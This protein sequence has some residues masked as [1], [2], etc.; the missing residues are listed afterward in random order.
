MT[1]EAKRNNAT[2]RGP[3]INCLGLYAAGFPESDLFDSAFDIVAAAISPDDEDDMDVDG[4]DGHSSKQLQQATV[5]HCL[6]AL[7]RCWR[8]T[9]KNGKFQSQLT[10][11]FLLLY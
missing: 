3:A 1:R 11:P 8:P 4:K 9:K 5:A 6:T 2:Y 7:A 10:D